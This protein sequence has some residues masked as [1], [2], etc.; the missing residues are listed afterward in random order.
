MSTNTLN[1]KQIQEDIT[2]VTEKITT[3]HPDPFRFI[4]K[5]KFEEN[6]RDLF[7]T[8]LSPLPFALKLMEI[9]A[10]IGDSHTRIT[11]ISRYLSGKIFPLALKY[12]DDGYYIVKADEVRLEHIGKK[13]VTIGDKNVT[14]TEKLI[15]TI[16]AH[17]NELGLRQGVELW[18]FEPEVLSHLGIIDSDELTFAFDDGSSCTVS[19]MEIGEE[20][21]TEPREKC[22]SKNETLDRKGA[23][24]TK[25][26]ENIKTFYLQYNE[27]EDISHNEMEAIIKKIEEMKPK[28]VVVDVRNNIGGSSRILDPLTE[29]L[30]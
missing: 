3:I 1:Q 10:K 12:I 18:S 25:E 2:F 6:R 28:R 16:V 4:P 8:Q 26:Y 21:L 29:Y 15:A 22:L 30:H 19:P 17:E 14:E 20:D 5:K 7:S 11:G 9:I 13:V 27:C 24:W 23:Y